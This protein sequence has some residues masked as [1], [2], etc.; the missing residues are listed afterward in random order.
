MTN[1]N[2]ILTQPNLHETRL[3][4]KVTLLDNHVGTIIAYDKKNCKYIVQLDNS[5]NTL[6]VTYDIFLSGNFFT[7]EIKKMRRI[8]ETN[9]MRNGLE[10]R[11]VK[12]DRNDDIIVRFPDGVEKHTSYQAFLLGHVIHPT[13][14]TKWTKR[15]NNSQKLQKE[16]F[17]NI[18][19]KKVTATNEI[20]TVK[21]ILTTSKLITVEFSDGIQTRVSL[22]DYNSKKIEHPVESA[23]L[24]HNRST[25]ELRK[26]YVGKTTIINGS[27]ATIVEYNSNKDMIVRVG[28]SK[29]NMTKDEFK[30]Y[31]ILSKREKRIIKQTKEKNKT[32][33]KE[34]DRLNNFKGE[35]V[36][37]SDGMP[38]TIINYESSANVTIKFIDGHIRKIDYYHFKNGIFTR[39]RTNHLERI[40]TIG[41]I[42]DGSRAICVTYRNSKDIAIQLDDETIIDHITWKAFTNGTVKRDKREL[43][44]KVLNEDYEKFIYVDSYKTLNCKERNAVIEKLLFSTTN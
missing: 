24:S 12:Y 38:A 1:C 34:Q 22:D 32:L 8:N 13:I 29:I 10:A 14:R 2:E 36:V 16:I 28:H 6:A 25:D 37:S 9:I 41:K 31:E 19:D 27:K 35:Q 7:R 18:G 23:T 4:E 5:E 40:G 3:G 42:A 20:C 39:Y 17:P 15:E 11:I 30:H 44:I 21:S 43:Y 33:K 26:V